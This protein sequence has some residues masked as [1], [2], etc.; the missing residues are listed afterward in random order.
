MSERWERSWLRLR[1]VVKRLGKEV[2]VYM[3][4]IEKMGKV[5]DAKC[6]EMIM[7]Q[8][9]CK[10]IHVVQGPPEGWQP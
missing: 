5:K 8:E 4:G 9:G 2:Q 10:Q 6:K 1:N 3:P 7:M